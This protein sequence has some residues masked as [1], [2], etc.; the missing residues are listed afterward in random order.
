M[1]KIISCLLLF[2]ILLGSLSLYGCGPTEEDAVLLAKAK[3]LTEASAKLNSLLFGEGIKAKE[4]G[5]ELGAYAEADSESLAYYGVES[6]TDI[7]LYI[8]SIYSK[9]TALWIESTVLNSTKAESQALTY[10]RY[11][12]GS[13]Q[14]GS[15]TKSGLM[16]KT[17]YE[18]TAV[19][20]VSYDNYV[21]FSTSMNEVVFLV[22]ITVTDGEITKVF[23]EERITM[24]KEKGIWLLDTTT[25]ASIK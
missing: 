7:K 10:A 9:A 23:P 3:E 18:A 11:Y 24:R 14:V 20:E 16:V 6:V 25:Y 1:K 13:W 22:D 15:E 8:G 4:G 17:N 5:Y 2:S 19:G 12:D 21:L